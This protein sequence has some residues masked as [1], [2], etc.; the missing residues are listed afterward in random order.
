MSPHG[1]GSL[2]LALLLAAAGL[3]VA[4]AAA[5]EAA[6]ALAED[7]PT[8]DAGADAFARR[9]FA[10]AA[11]LWREEAEAGSARA[12]LGLGLIADLGLG[13]PRDPARALRWY[14]EAAEDGLADAQFNVGVMLDA[15]AGVARDPAAASV[16]YA[17]AA[18]G[19]HL[20]AQYN[21][22]LLYEAGDGVPRNS[23]LARH[24]LGLAAA[25]LDAA[26]ERLAEVA[27]ADPGER[28]M[29]PPEILADALVTEDGAR[30]AELAWTA[31]PGP[32]GAPFLV[33]IL[34]LEEAGEGGG[35]LLAS[36]ETDASAV[37]VDL[38]AD[39]AAYAWRVSR[40]ERG[41]EGP[42]R[43]EASP[44]RRLGGAEGGAAEPPRGR[45]TV[46]VSAEDGPAL[47]LAR[48]L[49]RSL[50]ASGLWVR[51]ERVAEAPAESVV[52][53]AYEGDRD[54]AEGIAEFLPVLER[55][56]AEPAPDLGAAPGEVVIW[57]VGGPDEA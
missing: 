40:L 29:A 2:A 11:E 36:Q 37:A 34:A 49:E 28:A 1:A 6:D 4:G 3:P 48:E 27:P 57:L 26:R 52:R 9:D 35:A 45:V 7:A 16:W 5:Q 24:W 15:G 43:Y 13:V 41:G 30:R 53:Y 33:E 50:G 17:R 25:E 51:I 21:L 12:K 22:G 14:L 39:E 42:A 18:A 38:P 44:W 31:P 54:L 8:G 10:A 55:G 32:E 47:R 46:R 56:D 19:G 23:D 20:R